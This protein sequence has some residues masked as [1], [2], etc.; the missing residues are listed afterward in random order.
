MQFHSANKLK[1]IECGQEKPSKPSE[2]NKLTAIEC[3]QT[4]PSKPSDANKPTATE[5][6]KHEPICGSMGPNGGRYLWPAGSFSVGG[7]DRGGGHQPSRVGSARKA[8]PDVGNGDGIPSSPKRGRPSTTEG[9]GEGVD[10]YDELFDQALGVFTA[11]PRKSV[12][13]P[14]VRPSMRPSAVRPFAVR[15]F[16][17]RE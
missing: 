8:C 5:Y 6:R 14:D 2:A 11:N 9:G 13:P 17:A 12:C 7:Q 10:I 15:P 4:N 3:R 1:A 16:V